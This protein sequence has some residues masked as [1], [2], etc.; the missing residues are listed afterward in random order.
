MPPFKREGVIKVGVKMDKRSAQLVELDL[1]IPLKRIVSDLCRRADIL[2]PEK[3]A[4]AFADR[5]TGYIREDEKYEIR[6]GD[7]LQLVRA[8]ALERKEIIEKLNFGSLDEKAVALTALRNLSSDPVFAAEFIGNMEHRLLLSALEGG[9]YRGALLCKVLQCFQDLMEHGLFSWDILSVKCLNRIL[10]EAGSPNTSDSLTMETCLSVLE[11]AVSANSEAY[12]VVFTGLPWVQYAN[13]IRWGSP[14][15]L[16]NTVSLL[17]ALFMKGDRNQQHVLND[18]ISDWNLKSALW[19]RLQCGTEVSL[20]LA[21]ALFTF[22]SLLLNLYEE[23]RNAT[24][25][26]SDPV[27]AEKM[28]LLLKLGFGIAADEAEEKGQRRSL[29][30]STEY[31]ALGFRHVAA[32]IKDF[33]SPTGKFAIENLSYFAENHSTSFARV[34]QENIYCSPDHRCSLTKGS[35]MLSELLCDVFKIGEPVAEQG[36]FYPMFFSHDRFFEEMFSACMLLVF[37]TWR[38]MRATILDTPKVFGIVREQITRS[39]KLNPRCSNIDAFRSTLSSLPYSEIMNQLHAES[40]ERKATENQSTAV[41]ELRE[42]LKKDMIELVKQNRINV[43][44]KGARFQRY[45]AKGQ[46]MKDRYVYLKLSQ[47]LK[48][49]YYGDCSPYCEFAAIEDLDQ[50][51]L[52]TDIETVLTG[53][54][55]P[56]VKKA[57]RIIADLAFSVVPRDD[58]PPL[59][60][61]A[62]SLKVC[63]RWVDGLR[64]CLGE[65]METIEARGDLGILLD[66]E[67]RLRLLETEGVHIPDVPPPIPPEPSN[68]DFNFPC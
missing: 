53:L 36:V 54:S 9:L 63:H 22:Q 44:L 51:I 31:S 61:V 50:K 11:C 24:L 4:L 55:C 17:N 48:A 35:I 2:E 19:N 25:D 65:D 15:V 39:L 56:H 8:P 23:R 12:D 67:V 26:V 38:E 27:L 34:A 7:L 66:M 10:K 6:N 16:K 57:N 40:A 52:L 28:L 20:D 18:A 13:F 46:R 60:L 21:Q 5:K 68:L 37:K 58:E 1:S 45:S 62:P 59:N 64:A 14:S 49:L 47:N 33:M 30:F 42:S 41:K 29:R 32:P 3:Y 43:L